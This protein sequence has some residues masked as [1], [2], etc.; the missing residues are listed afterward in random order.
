[1]PTDKIAASDACARKI[2]SFLLVPSL[3]LL[4]IFAPR[5][6]PRKVSQYRHLRS[7]K[8]YITFSCT[9][10]GEH[11]VFKHIEFDGQPILVETR[12]SESTANIASGDDCIVTGELRRMRGS[13]TVE[14]TK[15]EYVVENALIRPSNGT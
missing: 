8:G 11:G 9:Y 7:Y 13:V 10:Q 3:V 2:V 1:M 12:R 15:V 4:A 6:F 14:T 5:L